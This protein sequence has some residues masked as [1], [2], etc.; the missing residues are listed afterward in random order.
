VGSIFLFQL[1][2]IAAYIVMKCTFDLQ[3]SNF[4]AALDEDSGDEAPA[5]A[6][7]V[8]KVTKKPA[9]KAIVEPSKPEE[10]YV[11]LASSR[12]QESLVI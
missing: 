6:P 3:T 11:T 5:T 4:F 1:S 12:K 9:T 2:H 8:K 7:A 10:R